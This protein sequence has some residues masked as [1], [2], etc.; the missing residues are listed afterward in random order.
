[1]KYEIA[2]EIKKQALD[3]IKKLNLYYIKP[4]RFVCVRSYGSKSNAIAR[5]HSLTK[6]MQ[7]VLKIEPMYV[8]EFISEKFDKLKEEEKIKVI[9]HELLHIPKNMSG[10]FRH[11]NYVKNKKVEF[12]TK[13]YLEINDNKI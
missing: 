9:I 12:L 1:M 5:C 8:L 6:I 7:L 3:I 10:G 2:H 13:K 4:E 11:H